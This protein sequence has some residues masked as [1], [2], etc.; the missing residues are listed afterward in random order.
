MPEPAEI[1]IMALGRF[2]EVAPGMDLPAL[3]HAAAADAA[4]QFLPGDILVVTQKIVSKAEGALVD[5]RTI[6]PSD[7]AVRWAAA[8]GKDPRQI[9]VVLRESKRVVRMANG[10]L[11]CETQHG[12]VCANAGVDASNVAG[13]D[14]VA[15][16]PR[17]PDGS[18]ARLRRTLSATLGFD[19]PVIISDSF[20]RAWRHGIINVAVGLAGLPGVV[21]YR[22][23]YDTNGYLLSATIIAIGDELASAAELVMG[24][25]DGRPAALI[26]GYRFPPAEGTARDLLM[27]PAR[28]LFR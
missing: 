24:K 25:L 23:Q 8:W 1:R 13:T 17:D 11:I 19:L 10:V 3:I 4:V 9:E 18:A 14:T 20:G 7:L 22:G 2:P 15:L 21:D 6:T 26:R 27:D 12:F 28:D 16:L 5:L